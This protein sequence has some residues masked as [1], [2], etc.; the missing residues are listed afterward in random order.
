MN[1]H[2]TCDA[3]PI[4]HQRLGYNFDPRRLDVKSSW[5]GQGKALGFRSIC[6]WKRFCLSQGNFKWSLYILPRA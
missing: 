2:A 6:G 5:I 1:M 3:P 4:H